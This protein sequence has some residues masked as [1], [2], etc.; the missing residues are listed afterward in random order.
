LLDGN[1]PTSFDLEDAQQQREDG[2]W[3]HGLFDFGAEGSEGTFTPRGTGG[4]GSSGPVSWSA[5]TGKPTTFTPSAHTH[6]A[7][8]V[9]DFAAAA[10]ARITAALA[11][12]LALIGSEGGDPDAFVN[13]VREMLTVFQNYPEGNKL[14]RR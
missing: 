4:E 12:I 2:T 9:S 3:E 1:T 6:T 13:A 8:E 5:I 10:D 7:A 11:P 14:L